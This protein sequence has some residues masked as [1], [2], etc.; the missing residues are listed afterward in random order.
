MK[1]LYLVDTIYRSGGMERIIT[2]KANS[3]ACD[4][5]YDVTILTNHQKGRPLFFPLSPK[6]RHVDIGVNYKLPFMM[7][8]YVRKVS[9]YILREKPDICISTCGKELLQ[10]HRLPDSC[11]K[12]AE[13]HFSHRTF[14]VKG[15]RAKL[16]KM[17]KAVGTLDSFVV[18]TKEDAMAWE[19]FSDKI[20][21]IYNPSFMEPS[22]SSAD[23][24][25]K[26]FISAGRFERQKN[27]QD[28]IAA[29]TIVHS[30][31]PDWVL[32][33]YGDGS[34]KGMI[35][36]MVDSSS[37][38]GSVRL[39]PATGDLRGEMLRS[40]GF[41]LSSIYE[42]F[43]LVMVEAASLGLPFISYRCPCGPGEFIEDGKDGFTVP[44]G[45]IDALADRICEYIDSADL[46]RSMSDNIRKKAAAFTVDS[47]M[48]LWDKL[49]KSLV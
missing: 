13:F 12:M 45:D 11:R 34:M 43:P 15:Q 5:G 46:R 23:L 18:L 30:M 17:E 2:A 39:H 24:Q 35:R 14:V 26:R 38:D 31:R 48:P 1:L 4:Y 3:L 36:A 19:P 10:M 41:L 40:A 7:G 42:G 37:L 27:F 29:W 49:F 28:L 22:D 44:V 21:Q 8:R 47:I 33:I 32:D 6:V 25:S 20:T 16:R 9:E